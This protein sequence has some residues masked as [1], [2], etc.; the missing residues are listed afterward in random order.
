MSTILRDSG[1]Y[2]NPR[3]N[4]NA[5][6][7]EKALKELVQRDILMSYKEEVQRGP[8]NKIVDI[9][10]T[11]YP[12]I[13]FTHEVKKANARAKRALLPVDNQVPR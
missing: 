7:I 4:S 5:R 1:S 13:N 9:V 12:S 2:C 6:E 8:R 10:Y 3:G 11:L